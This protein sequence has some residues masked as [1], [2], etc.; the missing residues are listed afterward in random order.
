M[1][2]KITEGMVLLGSSIVFS[3]LGLAPAMA[4]ANLLQTQRDTSFT[5]H[6]GRDFSQAQ[7]TYSNSM[8]VTGAGS[9][10]TTLSF[11]Y[12]PVPASFALTGDAQPY[13]GSVPNPLPSL[14]PLNVTGNWGFSYQ[15][16]ATPF[17]PSTNEQNHLVTLPFQGFDALG[18][19]ANPS[20]F[21]DPGG[22]FNVSVVIPG[23]FSASGAVA[24][25]HYF[26]NINPAF[27]ITNNF[28]YNASTNTTLF[29][30]TDSNWQ[31]PAVGLAFGL[32]ET[33]ASS[34]PE[35]ASSVLFGAGLL[36]MLWVMRK[37]RSASIRS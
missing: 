16:L 12:V 19:I 22:T 24:G 23:N 10:G 37:R 30:A 3:V 32:F 11:N 27:S 34:V 36:G 33:P 14:L 9:F 6:F 17:G 5:L 29:S 1:M 8:T 18:L 35:P 25:G 7:M 4:Y 31:S 2:R 15:T 28:V 13:G 20:G 21:L 26:F